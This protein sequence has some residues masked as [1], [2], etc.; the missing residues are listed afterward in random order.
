MKKYFVQTLYPDGEVGGSMNTANQ[1]IEM[2][3]FSDCTDCKFEVFDI[4]KF[5]SMVRLVY[6]PADHAPFNYHRFINSATKEVEFEG[7]SREH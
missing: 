7:Y 3:G 1:I 5:G 6:E 2:V 4:S